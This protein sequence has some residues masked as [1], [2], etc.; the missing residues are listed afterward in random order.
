MG[1]KMVLHGMVFSGLLLLGIGATAQADS[2]R[3]TNDKKLVK[4]L[5]KVNEDSVKLVKF[6]GMVAQFEKDKE[7][8]ATQAQQSAD[9]NKRAAERLADNPQDKKLAR[10][11]RSAARTAKNDSQKARVAA[12]KLND[13]NDDIKKLTRQLGKEQ[14][15][16]AS[17]QATRSPAI[18]AN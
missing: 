14:G 12:N 11:A 13:L 17:Y 3:V 16:L 4:L 6:N 2:T 18:S 5:A 15:K 7:N 9:D 10:R 8:A 1:K